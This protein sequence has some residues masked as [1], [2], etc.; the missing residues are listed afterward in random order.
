M[1]EGPEYVTVKQAAAIARVT[2]R[3]IENWIAK[4]AIQVKRSPVGRK[5]LIDRKQVEPQ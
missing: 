1:S 2:V 4:Q 5:L 3:T